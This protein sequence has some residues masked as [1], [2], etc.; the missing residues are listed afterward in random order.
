MYQSYSSDNPQARDGPADHQLLDLF[1]AFEDVVGR[2]WT[3]PQ[4]SVGA[5]CAH[6]PGRMLTVSVRWLPPT[7]PTPS[8]K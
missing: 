7:T 8:R 6:W 1:G 2:T 5:V 3:C 4:I